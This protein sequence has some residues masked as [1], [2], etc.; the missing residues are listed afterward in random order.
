[1]VPF[2][3]R[4]ARSLEVPLPI[5]I[6]GPQNLKK[7]AVSGASG[8]VGTA[9]VDRLVGVGHPF[10]SPTMIARKVI[11][12]IRQRAAARGLARGEQA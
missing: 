12:R 10:A 1:M 5:T 9:M 8:F 4:G 11:S 3:I 2:E 6:R 7:I